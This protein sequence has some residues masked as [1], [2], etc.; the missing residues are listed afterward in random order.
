MS[1]YVYIVSYWVPFPSSEYG[2]L[3]VYVA[4]NDD[5]VINMI[6]DDMDVAH[7]DYDE[8]MERIVQVVKKAKKIP[9]QNT[10]EMGH[11]TS[12]IT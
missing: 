9:A 8:A 7:Y 10:A 6:Y 12:F 5:Q 2:G 11:V 3:E 4:Q 1:K